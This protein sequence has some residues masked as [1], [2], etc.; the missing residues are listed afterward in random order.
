MRLQHT[1]ATGLFLML[2][3]VGAGSAEEE[4]TDPASASQQELDRRCEEAREKMIAPL[5]EA[6]IAR[7]KADKRNDPGFCERFF[8]SYGDATYAADGRYIPRMYSD[9][10]GCVVAE[11]E[12]K[13]RVRLGE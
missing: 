12:R 5:R 4:T 11:Q 2:S 9:L 13:R 10:P 3:A 6:E 8:A 7:C 1:L